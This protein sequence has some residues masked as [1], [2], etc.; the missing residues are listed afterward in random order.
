MRLAAVHNICRTN[1]LPS[2]CGGKTC[3]TALTRHAH[4][5]CR[6]YTPLHVK[7][8]AVCLVATV[9]ANARCVAEVVFALEGT[10]QF[11]QVNSNRK[12]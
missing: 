4:G 8:N 2:R 1:R 6:Y 9:P 5:T 7:D 3:D 12:I 11:D 10:A